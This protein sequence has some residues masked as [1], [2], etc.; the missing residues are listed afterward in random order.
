MAHTGVTAVVGVSTRNGGK[1]PRD[2]PARPGPHT[3][4][5]RV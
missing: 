2:C 1:G 3:P 5:P 4:S